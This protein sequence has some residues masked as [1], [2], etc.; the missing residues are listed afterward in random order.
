MEVQLQQLDITTRIATEVSKQY[1]TATQLYCYGI[2]NN[3][4]EQQQL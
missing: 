3:Y 4:K 2:F 1:N